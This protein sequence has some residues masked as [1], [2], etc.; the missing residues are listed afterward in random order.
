MARAFIGSYG[1]DFVNKTGTTL[2]FT[3]NAVYNDATYLTVGN[4]TLDLTSAVP[5]TSVVCYCDDYIPT[6]SGEV[7]VISSGA[8]VST[9]TTNVLN[10]FYD[11][12]IIYFNFL[13]TRYYYIL[14]FITI[15]S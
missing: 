13:S 3:E 5:G 10:F 7:F 4:L 1:S 6:I 11:G 9:N 15:G 2:V 8:M 14:Y 12:N